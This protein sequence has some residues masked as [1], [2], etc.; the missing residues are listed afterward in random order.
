MADNYPDGVNQAE[1]DRAHEEM[2]DEFRRCRLCGA[3][4]YSEE[5]DSGVCEDCEPDEPE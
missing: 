5:L 3:M 1:F 2:D 4:R